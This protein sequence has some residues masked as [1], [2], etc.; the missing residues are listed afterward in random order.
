[1]LAALRT[2]A[3]AVAL[4]ATASL[5]AAQAQQSQARTWCYARADGVSPDLRISGCT[6]VI[7]SEK[8]SN[9]D[10]ASAFYNRGLAYY[11]KG[12]HDRAIQDYDQAIKLKPSYADAFNNRGVAY[13]APRASTTAPSRTTTRPSSSTRATP[14]P[15]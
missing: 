14:S 10:L 11:A 2:I 4:V 13:K 1:M 9:N 3:C 6:T 5:D 15:F 7:Q 12:Q 8:L